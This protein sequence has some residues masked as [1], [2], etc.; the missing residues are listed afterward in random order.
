MELGERIYE[1]A[2]E[3]S[4]VAKDL[5]YL[6]DRVGSKGS[7]RKAGGTLRDSINFRP[8]GDT[9]LLLVQVYYGAYQEPN[10]LTEAIDDNVEE[11]TNII[12]T[13]IMEK[14]TESYGR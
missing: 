14:L 11:T 8:I 7:L 3:Q 5:Y 9:T 12:I 2:K 10:E 1:Q 4:R 13:E 6:T